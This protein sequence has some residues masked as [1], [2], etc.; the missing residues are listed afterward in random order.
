[1]DFDEDTILKLQKILDENSIFV[2]VF[3]L[4]ILTEKP[5]I[6]TFNYSDNDNIF[7]LYK[8]EKNELE[9]PSNFISL[10]LPN[11]ISNESSENSLN[12]S[13]YF[14]LKGYL[15]KDSCAKSTFSR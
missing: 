9:L 2:S 12:I 8:N 13:C 3:S 14:S 11:P 10:T 15:I 7:I 4:H 6:I 5:H 1:M